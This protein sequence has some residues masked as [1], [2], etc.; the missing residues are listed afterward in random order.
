MVSLPCQRCHTLC[1]CCNTLVSGG[2]LLPPL[3]HP[4]ITTLP[5]HHHLPTSSPPPY[6]LPTTSPLPP[7]YLPIIT[8][9]LPYYHLTTTLLPPHYHPTTTPLPHHHHHTTALLPPHFH[10]TTTPL[11]LPSAPHHLSHPLHLPPL[12]F[13]RINCSYKGLFTQ[14]PMSFQNELVQTSQNQAETI[15]R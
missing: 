4:S 14:N 1:G 11:P 13:D 3:Y 7:L 12:R 9:I 15:A 10:P 5:P 6:Y 8:S 2:T